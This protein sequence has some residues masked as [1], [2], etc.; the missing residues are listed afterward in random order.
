LYSSGM[1][2]GIDTSLSDDNNEI[3][4]DNIKWIDKSNR[5]QIFD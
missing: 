1:V 4:Q 3:L 2:R 5:N